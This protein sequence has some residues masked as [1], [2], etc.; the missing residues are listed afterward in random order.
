MSLKSCAF[1]ENLSSSERARAR[2]CANPAKNDAQKGCAMQLNGITLKGY[3]RQMKFIR[4]SQSKLMGYS[5]S[6]WALSDDRRRISGYAF[7]L[8]NESSLISWKKAKS[9]QL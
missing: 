7:K 9:N 8:C 6:D 3:S 1:I 4:G 5:D 2:V